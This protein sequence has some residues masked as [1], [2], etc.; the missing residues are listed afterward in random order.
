MQEPTDNSSSSTSTDL[1][2]LNTDT[3]VAAVEATTEASSIPAAAADMSNPVPPSAP[4]IP[5]VV[6]ATTAVSTE[7]IVVPGTHSMLLKQ[8]GIAAAIVVVMGVALWYVLE[9]QGRVQT[10]FFDAVKGLVVPEPAAV[11]VN[12]EK[13]PLS[14]YEKNREQ[15]SL[16]A[17]GQGM[18]PNDAAV[19]EQLKQQAL[20]LLIN[21]ALLRQ[22]ATAAGI[23][24]TDE[25]IDTRYQ[26]IVDSQ[27]G[28]EA[29]AARMAEL[30]ITK[31]GL[32]SDINDEI[33]IQTHLA[34]A[35]DTSAVTVTD[36]EVQALYDSVTSN[37]AVDVPPLDEV[38]PQIEQEIRFG[39]EQELISAYIETLKADATI[40]TLI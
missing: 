17:M 3:G 19:G 21:S 38:R 8:Y 5:A 39:K 7:A 16:Q 23:V 30:N 12:G 1:T 9:E 35:V 6:P 29:L 15:L 27:G 26:A 18:D 37:P 10:G 34:T 28:E 24:V 2:A 25:Q 40:E 11:I 20:D 14:L 4:E 13:V 22:A 32:M 33:L 36:A 31:D